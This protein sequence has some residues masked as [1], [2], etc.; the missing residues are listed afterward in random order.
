ME[1]ARLEGV[2]EG[3]LEGKLEIAKKLKQIGLDNAQIIAATGLTM[4]EITN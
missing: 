2:H 4:A 1:L 3:K